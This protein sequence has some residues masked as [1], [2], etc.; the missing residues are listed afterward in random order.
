MEKRMLRLSAARGDVVFLPALTPMEAAVLP[1]REKR[2]Y[3][4]LGMIR[5]AGD[6]GERF[7]EG[8]QRAKIWV[9]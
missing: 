6:A 5:R 3:G 7:C 1:A 8:D 2:T 4:V 9:R